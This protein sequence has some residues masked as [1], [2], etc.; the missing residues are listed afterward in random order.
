MVFVGS[1]FGVFP[2]LEFINL[3]VPLPEHIRAKLQ[4]MLAGV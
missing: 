2:F 4:A 3:S 1:G